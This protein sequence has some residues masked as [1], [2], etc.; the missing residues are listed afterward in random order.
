MDA[1]LGGQHSVNAPLIV[2]SNLTATSGGVVCSHGPPQ[3]AGP[4]EE[5]GPSQEA[6]PP[7]TKKVKTDL[8]DYLKEQGEREERLHQQQLEK[9]EQQNQ[10]AE[11]R[12]DRFLSVLEK[13]VEKM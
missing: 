3:E 8:L 12:A 4:S 11:A 1:A 6:T 2:A 13:L 5:A 10:A 7:P 9:M